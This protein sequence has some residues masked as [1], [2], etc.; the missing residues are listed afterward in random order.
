MRE[1]ENEKNC[2]M[3]YFLR[4]CLKTAKTCYICEIDE[5]TCSPRTYIVHFTGRGK[6][7]NRYMCLN[8]LINKLKY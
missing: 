4:T 7:N 2:D 5:Y 3:F 8:C 1:L 6:Y